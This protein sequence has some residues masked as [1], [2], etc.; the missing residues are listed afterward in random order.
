M[1][2][3]ILN[4]ILDFVIGIID[5]LLSAILKALLLIILSVFAEV[6]GY[7]AQTLFQNIVVKGGFI[8]FTDLLST[9]ETI[10]SGASIDVGTVLYGIATGLLAICIVLSG[11]KFM[12]SS[13]GGKEVDS[14]NG[15]VV[16]TVTAIIMLVGYKTFTNFLLSSLASLVNATTNGVFNISGLNADYFET[17]FKVTADANT[18][19][20][21]ICFVFMFL[22]VKEMVGASITFV[23]RYLFF[24]ISLLLGPV[25]I[26]MYPYSETSFSLKEWIKSI[27]GQVV[28]ILLSLF[29]FQLFFAQL[30]AMSEQSFFGLIFN[31]TEA[32]TILG[33]NGIA[34]ICVLIVLLTF[35]KNTEKFCNTIGIHA[36]PSGES[37]RTLQSAYG[38]AMRTTGKIINQG[39]EAINQRRGLNNVG[40]N[41]IISIGGKGAGTS[42]SSNNSITKADYAK[43]LASENMNKVM[44]SNPGLDQKKAVKAAQ[45]M[46]AQQLKD[47]GIGGA[48][49]G[50]LSGIFKEKKLMGAVKGNV[51][52]DVMNA[53][54]SEYDAISKRKERIKSGTATASDYMASE[55][56]KNKS[57]SLNTGAGAG[58]QKVNSREL[59]KTGHSAILTARTEN[60]KTV[61][62]VQYYD[63]D[64]NQVKDINEINQLSRAL[65]NDTSA[66]FSTMKGGTSEKGV[67]K[68]MTFGKV[69][70]SNG[71]VVGA[72]LEGKTH[73]DD[74][75]KGASAYSTSVRIADGN[76]GITFEKEKAIGNSSQNKFVDSVTGRAMIVDGSKNVDAIAKE[77][78]IQKIANTKAETNSQEYMDASINKTIANNQNMLNHPEVFNSNSEVQA[79]QIESNTANPNYVNAQVKQETVINNAK[80]KSDSFLQS[81]LDLNESKQEAK[82][83]RQ[84]EKDEKAHGKPFEKD[85]EYNDY[86]EQKEVN[87]RVHDADINEKVIEALEKRD[88]GGHEDE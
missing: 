6:A 13:I 45:Q 79:A 64:G 12:T 34:Q 75:G 14:P 8:T 10:L 35:V 76:N 59:A 2:S 60:G 17:F 3:K 49:S 70:N 86:K 87:Q 41:D 30:S 19:E 27:L 33:L 74:N 7:I 84:L 80:A 38:T 1:I 52:G 25:V 21:V 66:T 85:Q 72:S 22:L 62:A 73:V 26:A 50:G 16:R 51:Y 69:I 83:I 67:F 9:I 20:M 71:E 23:E 82:A 36:L 44:A 53:A 28:A 88:K 4:S 15:F 78:V 47:Q 57:F 68:D 58:L 39:K 29:L 42:G 55:M 40:K 31:T 43:K 77:N 24:G 54:A 56:N 48:G 81:D 32:G 46:T 61:A 37:F 18:A 65:Q 11:I 5:A 63:K